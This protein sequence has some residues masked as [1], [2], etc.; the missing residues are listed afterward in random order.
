MDNLCSWQ[1]E[2]YLELH[3]A[4]YTT[5]ANIKKMNRLLE[6]ILKDHEFLQV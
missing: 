4:T 1:G 3:N 6:S 5:Q 2:L